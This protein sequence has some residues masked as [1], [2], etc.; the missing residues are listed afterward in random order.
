MCY[1]ALIP[2]AIAAFGAYQ[3]SQ[4]A[5][6]QA[7]YQAQVASNNAKV[8]EWQAEDAKER[9]DQAAS[10]VRRKYA[11]LQG[12]QAA[13]LAARGLDISEGSANAILTDTDFF[14]DYDQKVTKSNAAREAW[15]YR[16]RAGNFQGDAAA[17]RTAAGNE[18]PL[19]SGA[20]AGAGAYFGGK[21]AGS[22]GGGG[23][24]AAS[25][26]GS[27]LLDAGTPVSDRWYS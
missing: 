17:Y 21:A 27:G 9:G 26:T 8:S 20:L 3:Q 7:N 11:A 6:T 12:T 5:K 10:Q 15:G 24:A 18:N 14:G 25:S 4:N 19:V 23:S 16:V 2:I 22:G 1:V 13:S